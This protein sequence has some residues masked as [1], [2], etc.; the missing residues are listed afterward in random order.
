MTS[1]LEISVIISTR[2]RAT[3]LLGCLQSLAAQATG[4]PFE[5]VVIDNGSSDST[6][7]LLAH[8][9]EKDPRFRWAREEHVGLSQGKN[10]GIR[11]ARGKLLLFTDD[12]TVPIAGWIEAYRAFFARHPDGLVLAGGPV[13]P[14]P[15]DLGDWPRWFGERALPDLA[16]LDHRTE[17]PLA[18]AEYV[19]GGNMAVRAETFAR[20]G[21][22]DET[23]GRRADDRGTYEDA[24]FEDRLRAAG[25]AVWFCPEALVRH[26]VN[27][28]TITPRRVASTAFDRGR[29]DFWAEHIPAYGSEASVPRRPLGPGVLR[30][31]AHLLGWA[32]WTAIFR[33]TSSPAAFERARSAAGSSGWA[34]DALRAGRGSSRAYRVAGRATF[35]VRGLSLRLS[36]SEPDR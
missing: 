7:E 34:L 24:E 22:W 1:D 30:L 14:V 31:A 13:Q 17:R 9:S 28:R 3:F 29:N 16:M 6:P 11:T 2:N 8:W 26:R 21:P 19:W 18:R 27:R 15:D 4:G 33:T 36:P 32:L 35:A 23:V 10:A 20:I 5:V 25:G 12:D